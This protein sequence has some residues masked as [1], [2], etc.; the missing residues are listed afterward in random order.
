MIKDRKTIE[1][2]NGKVLLEVNSYQC[3]NR[4]Y[5]GA[6]DIEND[7]PF[8]DI[9]VNLTEFDINDK[10]NGF[11]DDFINSDLFDLIPIMKELG[12]I[13]ESYGFKKSNFGNYELVDFNLEKLREYD[14]VGLDN[15]YKT[16]EIKI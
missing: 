4:L 12:I 2:N 16:K 1:F 14:P 9:T 8:G 7:E 3:N 15:Y 6:Y 13:K 5:V 10:S 11:I